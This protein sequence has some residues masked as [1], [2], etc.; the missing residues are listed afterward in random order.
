MYRY[1]HILVCLNLSQVDPTVLR[2]AGLL[3]RLAKSERAWCIHVVAKSNLPESFLK[4]YPQ[5]SPDVDDMMQQQLAEVVENNLQ[6][7]EGTEKIL[8]ILQGDKLKELLAQIEDNSI[9][10]T[11]VGRKKEQSG[12]DSL[13]KQLTRRAPC[14]V[15]VVPEGS[16]PRITS[17]L[18]AVDFTEFS[19]RALDK[20]LLYC[21]HLELP[22]L[23]VAHYFDL[24][25]GY[26][27]AGLSADEFAAKLEPHIQQEFD[28]FLAKVDTGGVTVQ[29]VLRRA[30]DVAKAIREEVKAVGAD[31]LVLGSRGRS[32]AASVLLGTLP[33]KL[34]WTIEIPMLVA[35]EKGEGAGLLK[36]LRD[37][38]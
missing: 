32:A 17:V 15:L 20:A 10:L 33:E 12:R 25:T 34:I 14:S 13:E 8:R 26:H 5:L 36:L 38:L 23:H 21:R 18:C 37:S 2:Y 27:K 3:T 28:E 30:G 31:L 16:A 22:T 9:D 24:P 19:K 6:G 7:F 4:E 11:I 35:K 1:K 29:R